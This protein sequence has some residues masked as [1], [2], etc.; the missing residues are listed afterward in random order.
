ML[1]NVAVHL[2]ITMLSKL[3]QETTVRLSII[4]DSGCSRRIATSR[5]QHD[6]E[7]LLI[8]LTMIA[9][10]IEEKQCMAGLKAN[11]VLHHKHHKTP[12]THNR[13]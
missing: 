10:N 12:I 2:S 11:N 3:S 4:K 7:A 5:W 13:A 9:S 8:Q 6:L 1:Y